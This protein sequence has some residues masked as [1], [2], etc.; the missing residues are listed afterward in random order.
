MGKKYIDE[1]PT[2]ANGPDSPFACMVS[3]KDMVSV[4]F[5]VTA[6]IKI[7]EPSEI[8]LLFRRLFPESHLSPME[9]IGGKR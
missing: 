8:L 7:Y 2:S 1:K 6:K 4:T 5:Y 9:H 3:V